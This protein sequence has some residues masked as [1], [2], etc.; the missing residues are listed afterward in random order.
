MVSLIFLIGYRGVGKSTVG[1]VFADS[2]GYDFIDTDFII[3]KRKKSSISDIVAREG[4]QEFRNCEK[5]VLRS[6]NKLRR[7]VVATCGGAILHRG[8]WQD[9]RERSFIFWLTAD[10]DVI[11]HRIY[12]DAATGSQRPSLTGGSVVDELRE[13]LS[14]RIPLYQQTAH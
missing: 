11:L 14:K 2:L 13:I 5:E 1:K 10:E 7:S 8:E 6:M 4:W 12:N 3:S 9:L